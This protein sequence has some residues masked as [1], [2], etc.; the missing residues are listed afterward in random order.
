MYL[1]ISYIIVGKTR[2]AM[3]YGMF[4]VIEKHQLTFQARV[5]SV[6]L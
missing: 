2:F 5:N 3:V 4:H 1:I 6:C